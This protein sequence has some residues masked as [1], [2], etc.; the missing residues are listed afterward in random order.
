MQ[1]Q[2]LDLKRSLRNGPELVAGDDLQGRYQL[3]SILGTGG[4]ATVWRAKDRER[5]YPVAIKVLHGQHHRSED[6]T[7]RFFRGARIMQRLDHPNIVRVLQPDGD[8][9]GHKF[10]VMEQLRG[11]D[12][13]AFFKAQAVSADRVLDLVQA[14]AEGLAHAHGQGVVHRDVKPEN[15]LLST[16]GVPKMADFDLVMV[17]DSTGGTRTGALGSMFYAAPE[18][19][20][21][22]KDADARADVYSLAMTAVVGL[23]PQRPTM[24]VKFQPDALVAKLPVAEPV[25]TVL[26][27]ALN[28][29]PEGRPED[30]GRFKALLQAARSQPEPPSWA[31]YAGTD[32]YGRWAGV[33]VGS[34]TFKMRWMAP[35]TFL[36]GSPEDEP[37][38]YDDEGPQHPVTLSQGFW[39]AETAC[40]Q[41]LWSAVMSSNPSRF[42]D[43]RRPV[44]NERTAPAGQTSRTRIPRPARI[45]WPS[46]VPTR[47]ASTIRWA[48]YGSGA[49][50]MTIAMVKRMP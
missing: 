7:D 12:L 22:A 5:G 41:A 14:V 1:A 46:G 34:V 31:Q 33:R 17:G 3:L 29:E 18:C 47:G 21:Q 4:F 23:L 45:R 35:E 28:L 9:G 19:M 30:A 11:G 37:G 27:Q 48:T 26:R 10:F 42:A 50:T 43:P 32:E 38:R 25:R 13:G 2:I 49:M 8:D 44:E 24:Q 40:S 6:R 36:M 39:M 16:K 15:I 20:E